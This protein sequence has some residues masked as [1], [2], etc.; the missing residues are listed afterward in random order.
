M[1]PRARRVR[2]AAALVARQ[3]DAELLELAIQVRALQAGLLGDARHRAVFLARGGTRSSSSRRRRAPRAAGGRGRSSARPAGPSGSGAAAA[4]CAPPGIG[5][6]TRQA[7]CLRPARRRCSRRGCAR[8]RLGQRLLH[9]A[10]QLLQRDRLFEEGQGAEL[11]GLDRGVDGAVAA[12]HDHRHRQ[13]AAAPHSLSSVM[14]STSGIQ[15]S[16]STRSGRMRSR[17]ARACAAFSASSTEWPSSER[18]SDSRLADAQLVVDHQNRCHELSV[19]LRCAAPAARVAA[20]RG[21]RRASL[22]NDNE[23]WAPRT[24]PPRR[25]RSRAQVGDA[26]ARAV[27]VGD[28]LAPPP[29]PG[30][31]LWSWSSR[32]A[33]RRACSTLSAKAGPVVDARSGAPR[34]RRRCRCAPPR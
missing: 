9:G 17:T 11:G 33:R 10:Q 14:P 15:M 21:R 8:R 25:H 26:H 32:R 2:P 1:T 34:A 5:A 28:L 30:R 20:T 18:I 22:E 31:C 13:Q 4:A 16:S 7:D 12:H 6:S 29:G 19:H 24:L 23:T 27:F 3:V